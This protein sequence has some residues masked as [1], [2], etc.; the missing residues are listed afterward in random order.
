MGDGA[1]NVH[2]SY[3]PTGARPP[4]SQPPGPLDDQ[5]RAFYARFHFHDLPADLKCAMFV[6]KSELA[7]TGFA[8]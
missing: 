6:R 1:T 5:V 8:S 2:S 3:G 7:A 4:F